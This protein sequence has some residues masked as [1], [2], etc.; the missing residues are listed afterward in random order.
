MDEPIVRRMSQANTDFEF[1]AGS[2]KVRNRYL[3]KRLRRS[4]DWI[5]FDGRCEMRSFFNGLGNTD[6]IVFRREGR[7]VEGVTLRLFNPDTKQ[8]SIYWADNVRP[9]ILLPPMIG[10]FNGNVG[11]FY[12][13]EKVDDRTVLCRFL[14]TRGSEPRWEQAFSDDEGKTWETNWIMTFIRDSS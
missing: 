10:A 7:A 4:T 5:E 3:R 8:W 9:G 2:W 11:E 13:D 12:G 6:L 14:W 1:L